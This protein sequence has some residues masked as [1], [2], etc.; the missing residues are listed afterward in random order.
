[1]DFEL[2]MAFFVGPGN[3]MGSP[4]NVG[5]AEEH[6]FGLVLMNDW[7]ARDIQGWEYV[8]LG[9]FN[10]KN[11]ATSISPWIVT[12]DALEP[13]RVAP[14][15]Q[16]PQPLP[17]LRDPD[18]KSY[19]IKLEVALQPEGETKP[20]TI[21]ESNA[22]YLYWSFTQQLAHHS[23]TGCP[24]RPGDLCGSGTISGPERGSY[25]SMLEISWKGAQSVKLETGQERKFIADG[26]NVILTG[27]C[28]GEGYRVGFGSV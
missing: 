14:E 8:P 7:S 12:M 5:Q 11:F 4:I 15:K 17:Y 18:L 19:D 10:G 16:E 25:G 23:S 21:C 3:P 24:M 20:S 22:R 28:Q 9:P 13:F 27:F 6:I 26:D 1:M 2:E